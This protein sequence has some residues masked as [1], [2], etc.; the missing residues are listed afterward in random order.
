[1]TVCLDANIVIYLVEQNPLWEPKV[2]ARIAAFRAG[3]DDIAVS[4]AARLECL[5]GPFRTGN[6]ADLASYAIFFA[7]PTPRMLAVTV[8]VWER[9]ARI[10]ADHGFSAL[11]SLHLATTVEHGCT[12]FLT[13]DDQLK[14]FPDVLVE[15]LS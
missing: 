7:S 15:V 2:S 12:R 10:R 14:R 13:N 8:A 5:V 1:M 4:D 6:T 11:D 9:A 3:G